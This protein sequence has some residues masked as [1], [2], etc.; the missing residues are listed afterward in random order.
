MWYGYLGQTNSAKLRSELTSNN[1][2]P[3]YS[4]LSGAGPIVTHT[5]ASE[6]QKM[7]KEE[8]TEPA[9]TEWTGSIIFAP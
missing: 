7:L 5:V 8:V 3:V 4:T 9:S 1:M 6:I 2:R